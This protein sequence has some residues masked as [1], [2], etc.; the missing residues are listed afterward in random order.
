MLCNV[1]ASANIQLEAHT[2]YI[3]NQS[4]DKLMNC[5]ESQGSKALYNEI[6]IPGEQE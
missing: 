6:C 1:M 4:I 5:I 2:F 3:C